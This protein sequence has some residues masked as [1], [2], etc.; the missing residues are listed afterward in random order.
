MGRVA[1]LFLALALPAR[2]AAPICTV[3]TAAPAPDMVEHVTCDQSAISRYFLLSPALASLSSAERAAVVSDPLRYALAFM[4]AD[5]RDRLQAGFADGRTQSVD[6]TETLVGRGPKG[7]PVAHVLFRLRPARADAAAIDWKT[8]APLDLFKTFP[9][10]LSPY[11]LDG[12]KPKPAAKP[13][14]P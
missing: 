13:A 1:G 4:A 6:L 8:L 12:L 14:S 11:L 7:A 2:A 3:V 5:A 10:E 9:S